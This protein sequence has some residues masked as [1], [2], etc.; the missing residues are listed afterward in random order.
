MTTDAAHRPCLYAFYDLGRAPVTFDVMN[1]FVFAH[2]WARRAGFS[3]YHV[4][5][6]LAEGGEFRN[7]TPKDLTLPY[8]EKVWRLWHVLMPHAGIARNCKGVSF[9]RD[10]QDL[11][12][13]MRA[14]H[15]AQIVPPEYSLD[16]PNQLFML[17]QI[18]KLAPTLEEMDVF[19]PTASALERVDGWLTRR[20]PGGRAVTITLRTSRAEPDRNSRLD[21]WLAAARVM[22][23]RG[24]EPIIV[25]DTDVVTGGYDMTIFGD[26][27]VFSIGSI[28][29]DLRLAMFRRATLNI[30][31]NGGPAFLS[32]FMGGSTMLC[33]LPVEKL[34]A[35]V[36]SGS[37][38]RMAE[39]L[40]VEEGGSFPHATPLRRF[41][42]RPDRR[43]V[44]VEEFD[45][46][47]AALDV[48]AASG[49]AS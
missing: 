29:L 35:I 11:A 43:E 39:L 34:P 30:A 41:I 48:Q 1:F 20:A 47:V 9:H 8:D 5:Y 49:E 14:I 12:Q 31:D 25:P 32:Y 42:W 19:A 18:F 33:F 40:G 21:E 6:V 16:K 28:D 15:P 17:N 2:V 46:A 23:E 45:K 3:G 44:I 27:P 36:G 22:R 10:R 4:V 7:L 13:L 24:F 38:R 37:H 26:L